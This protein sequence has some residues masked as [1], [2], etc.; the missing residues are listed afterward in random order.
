MGFAEAK[1]LRDYREVMKPPEVEG[2]EDGFN[3]KA[4]AGALFGAGL[5]HV[6]LA[7][8]LNRGPSAA[9]A[10][11][12]VAVVVLGLGIPVLPFIPCSAA[13]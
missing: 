8:L 7:R 3:W 12:V 11:F 2:V 6:V 4:V 13:T 10:G 5:V 9:R 1:E